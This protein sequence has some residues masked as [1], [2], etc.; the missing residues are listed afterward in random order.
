MLNKMFDFLF[1]QRCVGCGKPGNFLCSSCHQVIFSS[2]ARIIWE[3]KVLALF[4]Y[5]SPMGKLIKQFKYRGVR[6]LEKLIADLATERL[7]Q[8]R[9]VRVWRKNNFTFLPVP[10]FPTRRLWRGF[11]QSEVISKAICRNL[12]L[13]FDAEVLIRRKWTREQAK[14]NSVARHR[15]VRNVFGIRKNKKI[16]GRNFVIF[17]DVWTT[18]ATVKECARA[19]KSAGANLVWGLVLAR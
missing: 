18:G 12:N 5:Y 13:K 14:L 11:N 4:S 9:L 10:L 6:E 19:L 8:R 7:S 3:Q 16:E 15:N 1:P 2:P 17:D